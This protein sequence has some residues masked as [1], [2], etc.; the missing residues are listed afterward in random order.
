MAGK[1][2]SLVGGRVGGGKSGD[3]P[4]FPRYR[5]RN[6]ATM[7]AWLCS[8]RL[9][10]FYCLRDLCVAFVRNG[11]ASGANAVGQRAM[12]A[13]KALEYY[14][15]QAKERQRAAGGDRKSEDFRR[16][17]EVYL[18]GK[19]SVVAPVPEAISSNDDSRARSN[20]GAK[21]N[22]SGRSVA[23]AQFVK[24][25][26]TDDEVKSVETGKVPLKT[27][28]TAVRERGDDSDT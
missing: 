17:K 9:L 7:P 11:A 12:A 5:W 8:A 23:A 13:E 27:V 14:S 25:H 22:V 16:E 2:L 19:K 6:S 10:R 1:S 18:E 3:V 20:A 21:F 26:G 4:A 24:Q 28:E 15:E